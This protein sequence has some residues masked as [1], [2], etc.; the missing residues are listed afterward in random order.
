MRRRTRRGPRAGLSRR[1]LLLEGA[2]FGAFLVACGGDE[3][4]GGDGGS[5][6][7]EPRAAQDEPR[8][9]GVLQ[10]RLPAGPS[11]L[12]LHTVTSYTAVWP[13]TPAFN[14]LLQ[15]D[16]AKSS[17]GPSDIVPDLAERIEQPDATTVLFHLRRGVSFHDGSPFTSEDVRAQLEW[18]ASPPAG[19]MSPRK[20]A[21]AP[22]EAIERPDA[23]TVR[24]RL[25]RP[26]PSL[27]MHLASHLFAIGQA[28][29]IIA[30]GGV[31]DR[32]IGTG[33]YKL[34]GYQRGS[35]LELERNPSYHLPG[36]PYLDGLRFT[37]QPD[38]PTA[39]N[40]FIAGQ[41]QI[42]FDLQLKVSHQTR[43]TDELGDKVETSL[44]PSTFHDVIF[45]NARRAPY[46]DVRVRQAI[47][48]ALDRDA[49]IK[50]V[51][52]GAA[53][54]GGY[55]TPKGAWAFPESELRKV[56]GYD[57]PDIGKA[58]QLLA[59][60]GVTG[61]L[62]VL[63]PARTDHKDLAEF[64]KD[65]LSKIGITL[66]LS[67]GDAATIQPQ[68]QRGEFDIAPYV[69]GIALDDPDA[70]FSELCTSG[71]AR[72]WSAVHDPEGLLDLLYEKQS[73]TINLDE[74]RRLVNDLERR[75]LSL[76]QHAVIFLEDLGHARAKTVQ[77]FTLQDSLYTN[78]R[79]E[80]T[81]LRV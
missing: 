35:L 8:R 3:R 72:N 68:L 70:T 16:P 59:A 37:I 38:L 76:H 33:P 80:A 13:V 50:V 6:S 34:K 4:P 53:K 64:A 32:L 66:R 60:A 20:Q 52:E 77:N 21:L 12:N 7:A 17:T 78:R 24:L 25:K 41:S 9:G 45:A 2:A 11:S 65:Q 74:R 1:R 36:L 42:L 81:W 49:G 63:A 18:I 46:S 31:S 40:E 43:L 62:E 58:R 30:S 48:L 39:I 73:Q 54:R 28:A 67:F 51:K 56:E 79:M 15:F 69:I 14:Q 75:A 71:A 27:L 47:N 5:G 57:K 19:N 22:V 23:Q 10:Q 44:V 61:P 29:D 55:M 26:A